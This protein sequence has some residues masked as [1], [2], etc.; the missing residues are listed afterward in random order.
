MASQGFCD[1]IAFLCSV[2]LLTPLRPS[3]KIVKVDPVRVVMDEGNKSKI[4]DPLV[5][6]CVREVIAQLRPEFEKLKADVIAE[7]RAEVEKGVKEMSFDPNQRELLTPHEA[8]RLV[9]L[10]SKTIFNWITLGDLE[11]NPPAGKKR[12]RRIERAKLMAV[13]AKKKKK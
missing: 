13:Y 2:S 4:L 1:A 11:A 10:S 9:G 8:A 5:D 12:G 3:E 6:A 7:M